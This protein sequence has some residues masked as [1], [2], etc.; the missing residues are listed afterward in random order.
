MR[1]G[2][3]S[4]LLS[5]P[6][7]GNPFQFADHVPACVGDDVKIG[8]EGPGAAGIVQDVISEVGVGNAQMLRDGLGGALHLTL[9]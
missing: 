7:P 8:D 1:A 3:E 2:K 6:S 9:A 4:W 5:L